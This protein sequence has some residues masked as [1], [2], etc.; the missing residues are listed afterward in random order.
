[1]TAETETKM[2]YQWIKGD[3]FGQVVEVAETQKDNKWLWFDD[4]TRINPEL[5]NEFLMPITSDR[6]ILQVNP[7]NPV[8][9][10]TT[11]NTKV[12]AQQPVT[13]IMQTAPSALGQMI[14][15]MSKKNVIQVPIEINI[16]VPTPMLYAVLAEGMEEEELNEEI[17]QVA[18]S[19]IEIDKL[20]D[21]IQEQI[22]NFLKQYY[23]QS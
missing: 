7:V 18:V 8:E 9:S 5:I 2:K 13:K 14:M 4:G 6:E 22:T 3:R 12:A 16:N 15:K 19:Q 20:Q 23:V 17:T 10:T 11:E 21:Y 1:M